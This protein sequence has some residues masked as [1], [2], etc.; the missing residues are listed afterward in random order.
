MLTVPARKPTVQELTELERPWNEDG[1]PLPLDPRASLDSIFRLLW[2][3]RCGFVLVFLPILLVGL[4]YL[5]LAP[6]YYMAHA[7]LIVGSRQPDLITVAREQSHGEP[8]IDGAVELV[9]AEPALNHVAHTL[10]L[11]QRP[12]FQSLVQQNGNPALIKLRQLIPAGLGR[13]RQLIPARLGSTD[14]LPKVQPPKGDS[15]DLIASRLGRDLKVERIGRSTLLDVAYSSTDPSLAASVVNAV[16]SFSAKDENFLSQM[17]LAERSGFQIVKTSVLVRAL[18]PDEPSSPNVVIILVGTLFCA[19]ATALSAVLMKEY[20][21]EQTVLSTEEVTR[22]GL[23]ALGFIPF[24]RE[25]KRRRW[26]NTA[27]IAAMPGDPFGDSM[28]S[29]HAA[30]STSI[31]AR[32]NGCPV[33]LITSALEAE[34]KST[35]AA[36]LGVAMVASGVRVLL[37]DADLRSPT[38]HRTFELA[39]SP[40]LSDCI[41]QRPHPDYLIQHDPVSGVH[42]IS[43]GGYHQR[44]LQVLGQLYYMIES[45]REQYDIILIDSPPVLAVGDARLLARLADQTVVVARWGKTSWNVLNHAIRVLV[46]SGACI[47]G[48]TVSCVNVKQLA[49]YDYA[50]G[51]IYGLAYGNKKRTRGN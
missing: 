28:T 7:T 11:D 42:L 3:R 48:V 1:L 16:A 38:L 46:E 40:G 39:F 19:F 34:G 43:A 18:P 8:D 21:A 15:F 31:P 51:R 49:R 9:R 50:D 5:L 45:W 27:T 13:L 22:R 6:V 30:I 44:P 37:I 25:I 23:R 10:Q 41:G 26:P 36:A 14:Y 4:G 35:T 47:A 12:E 33:L 2:R 20:R 29:L 24:S 32:G 17:T